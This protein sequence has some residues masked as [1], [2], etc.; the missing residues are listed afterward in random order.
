M[1]NLSSDRP[2]FDGAFG[3]TANPIRLMFMMGAVWRLAQRPMNDYVRIL[4]I[5]SWCGASALTFGQGIEEYFAGNGS[6]TCVDAWEPYVD[7]VVNPD[8]NNRQMNEVLQRDQPF[9]VFN[10]NIRFLPAT[11]EVEIH[12]GWSSDV[13]PGLPQESFDLVYIDGDHT[14][15]GVEAD[16]R[17]SAGLVKV[18]GILCGDDLEIQDGQCDL[19]ILDL[20]PNIDSYYDERNDTYFHPGVTKA[21]GEAFGQVSAWSGFWA[22]EKSGAGWNKVSLKGMLPRIPKWITPKSLIGLKAWLM[23]SDFL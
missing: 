15:A 12:R 19:S 23:E 6:I 3:L 11:M 2:N 5:G 10:Q 7:L 9:Q 21:V 22:M 16:I 8:E 18:G 1:D 14:Y 13:L 17:N 4:E 20:E